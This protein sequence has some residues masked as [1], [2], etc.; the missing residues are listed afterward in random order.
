MK[1]KGVALLLALFTLLL[2]S[3]LVVAFYEV[4]TIDLQITSNHL[5]K[6]QALYIADAGIEYA[7]SRL[8]NSRLDFSQ[9]IEFPSGSGNNY[10]VNVTSLGISGKI[11]LSTGTLVS[12]QA[13]RLEAKVSVLGANPPYRVKIIYWREL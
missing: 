7:I 4:T 6:N 3:L 2:V 5:K 11:I 12:G 10:N 8:R 9:G 13:V 1:N